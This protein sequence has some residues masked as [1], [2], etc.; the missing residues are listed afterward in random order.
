MKPLVYQPLGSK[1]IQA[2]ILSVQFD[3]FPTFTAGWDEEDVENNPPSSSSASTDSHSH[4]RYLRRHCNHRYLGLSKSTGQEGM[5]SPLSDITKALSQPSRKRPMEVNDGVGKKIED[6]ESSLGS[7]SPTWSK[8]STTTEASVSASS[9]SLSMGT[10]SP[11]GT[12]RRRRRTM[13]SK[14]SSTSN[15]SPSLPNRR[16]RRSTLRP[17]VVASGRNSIRNYFKPSEDWF[18]PNNLWFVAVFR[19]CGFYC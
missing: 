15:F 10:G 2:K 4:H 3:Q 9:S 6:H 16:R 17:A 18:P 5:F 12:P 7:Q 1:V 14:T 13:V 8:H 11:G 19:Q